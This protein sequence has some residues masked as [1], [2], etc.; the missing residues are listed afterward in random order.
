[1]SERK[2]VVDVVSRQRDMLIASGWSEEM[3][4]A[5]RNISEQARFA[6]K[7][8][9][10]TQF[11]NKC[12]S[13][14]N[15]EFCE[16]DGSVSATISNV[17][18][19]FQFTVKDSLD[20]I[21]QV[22]G[23]R[24]DMPKI[25]VVEVP[26][27][28]TT[29]GYFQFGTDNSPTEIGLSADGPHPHFTFIHEYGHFLDNSG[30]LLH[31]NSWNSDRTGDPPMEAFHKA[32]Q[33]SQ[34]HFELEIA[35]RRGDPF[36]KGHA[37][38]LLSQRETFARAYT[39]WIATKTG[40][41]LLREGLNIQRNDTD[42]DR[43]SQWSDEEFKPIS[44]AL[45]AIFQVDTISASAVELHL[46]GQHDQKSH[47]QRGGVSTQ[48]DMAPS[49]ALSALPRPKPVRAAVNSALA[50]IDSV[51]NVPDDITRIPIQTN[52]KLKNQASYSYRDITERGKWVAD[53]PVSIEIN[54]TKSQH[55]EL[56]M[57]H[58]YGHYL[59]SQVFGSNIGKDPDL[60]KAFQASKAMEQ[61]RGYA[62]NQKMGMQSRKRA[63]YYLQPHETFARAYA[64]WVGLRSGN[65]TM[66]DQVLGVLTFIHEG[67]ALPVYSASQWSE[68][69]FAPIATS[70]DELFKKKGLLK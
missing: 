12:H 15:G 14:E 8:S 27:G 4:P 54:P 17:P 59:D 6:L 65:K 41:E 68:K 29:N 7:R 26:Q 66:Q 23:V 31:P 2:N 47:G 21:S 52:S 18:R 28:K 40:N 39:Q 25:P 22:H 36:E 51:H 16:T 58:E 35:S 49:S 38:Y 61:L 43:F 45:D 62:N 69:D 24:S 46:Q 42:L 32:V 60:Q 3:L 50:A 64:Q 20:L 19:Y 44:D 34:E 63:A 5:E 30:H 53:L 67:R 9:L 37:N 70:M 13:P 1:M 56:S 48:A 33:K 57:T 11:Y 55:M 10:V